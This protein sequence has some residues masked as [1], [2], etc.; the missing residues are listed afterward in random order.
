ML[1]LST[2]LNPLIP[3][4]I[5]EGSQCW[6][7]TFYP[8]VGY[9]VL[10][11]NHPGFAESTVRQLHYHFVCTLLQENEC[12]CRRRGG[13]SFPKLW[14]FPYQVWGDSELYSTLFRLHPTGCKGH[15]TVCM[16]KQW[17]LMYC[18]GVHVLIT[19]TKSWGRHFPACISWSRCKLLEAF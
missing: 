8:I 15:Y 14:I 13:T 18:T 10:G 11:W 5:N 3:S 9:S 4:V 2:G 16:C 6:L 19:Y 17:C 7:F 1:Q 12:T